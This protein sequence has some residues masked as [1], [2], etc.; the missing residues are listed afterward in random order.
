MKKYT[1]EHEW[2]EL[3]GTNRVW[4]V[5]ITEYAQ[6]QLGDVVTL[7]LPEIG[8]KLEAGDSCAVIESVKSA[9]D[10]YSP[11]AGEVVSVNETL[12]D[13]PELVNSSAEDQGWLFEV[14]V[15][16]EPELTEFMD[17]DEYKVHTAGQ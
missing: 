11:F 15:E 14:M 8:T 16:G 7:E 13:E 5:G 6:E 1:K 4:K 3:T 9:S 12:A 2:T 17:A 10:I